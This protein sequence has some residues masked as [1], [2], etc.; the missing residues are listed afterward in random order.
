MMGGRVG[1]GVAGAVA[2]GAAVVSSLGAAAVVTALGAAAIVAGGA[3]TSAGLTGVSTVRLFKA[4]FTKPQHARGLL[5]SLVPELQPGAELVHSV[6]GRRD[7]GKRG[8]SR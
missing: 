1:F 4:A 7:G 8:G 2:R 6:P 5:R 3:G